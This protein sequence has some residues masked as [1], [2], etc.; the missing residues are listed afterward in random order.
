MD[1][2]VPLSVATGTR[3]SA[4]TV[5]SHYRD[6]LAHVGVLKDGNGNKQWSTD[7]VEEHNATDRVKEG[8]LPPVDYSN[9]AQT[10][11]WLS[12][13]TTAASE[14][15][16]DVSA[17]EIFGSGTSESIARPGSLTLEIGASVE[18]SLLGVR[19]FFTQVI[20]A[21]IRN[22]A[23]ANQL[24][25]DAFVDYI[26]LSTFLQFEGTG[27]HTVITMSQALQCDIVLFHKLFGQLQA[28]MFSEFGGMD[29]AADVAEDDDLDDFD[30]FDLNT[31]VDQDT[32]P[33]LIATAMQAVS[34]R[35]SAYRKDTFRVLA[36]WAE[37]DA[38]K[39]ELAQALSSKQEILT[40]LL[41]AT[42]PCPLAELYPL[43]ATIKSLSLCPQA[44][45][46]LRETFSRVLQEASAEGDLP[47]LVHREFNEATSNILRFSM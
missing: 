45:L 2:E 31:S 46:I 17:K 22:G 10:L 33:Q 34:P 29:V 14:R 13:G 19:R 18:A 27:P 32:W 41:Q 47:R 21:E 42:A 23:E 24:E 26:A 3:G 40:G 35:P 37:L 28:A 9:I 25:V 15:Q 38:C 20:P 5:P 11:A 4:P 8:A 1:A 12:Q 16:A 7:Q 6:V 44:S 30:G 36:R 39:V 43:A